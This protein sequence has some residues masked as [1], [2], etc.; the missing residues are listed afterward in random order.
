MQRGPN[1]KDGISQNTETDSPSSTPSK[2]LSLKSSPEESQGEKVARNFPLPTER[3]QSL[4]NIIGSPELALDLNGNENRHLERSSFSDTPDEDDSKCLEEQIEGRFYINRSFYITAERMFQLL[5]TQSRFM[6]NFLKSRKVF[7]LESTPWQLDCNGNQART[8][9]YT[10]T[11]NNPLIG[12]FTTATEKQVLYKDHG[13]HTYVVE[14][15]VLTHDVPYH[16]YFY[17]VNKFFILRTSTDKCRLRVCTDVKY[18]KQPWGL[19][20]TFIERNSWSGLEDYFKQMTSELMMEESSL[21][22]ALGDGGKS[23]RR[24]RRNQNRNVGDH[25]PKHSAQHGP[26]NAGLGAR[27]ELSETKR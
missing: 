17:T 27:V 26:A 12:K 25:S 15:E 24:R 11:I 14:A 2:W 13:G 10:I 1:T 20:K 18:R 22:S 16:D 8:V 6:H 21:G 4:R 5:F 23:L 7:D 19:V 3:K 9:T